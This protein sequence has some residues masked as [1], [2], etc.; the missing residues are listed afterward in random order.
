MIFIGKIKPLNDAIRA[1]MLIAFWG[2]FERLE[3]EGI[4]CCDC[5]GAESTTLFPVEAMELLPDG[6]GV[7]LSLKTFYSFHLALSS[8]HYIVLAFNLIISA[9]K[10]SCKFKTFESF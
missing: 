8:V 1:S 9:L 2:D 7:V 10:F 3:H 6:G 5:D 4:N